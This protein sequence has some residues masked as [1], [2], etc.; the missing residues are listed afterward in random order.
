MKKEIKDLLSRRFTMTSLYIRGRADRI[1]VHKTLPIV[2]EWEVKTHAN[3]KYDDLTME[4]LPLAHHISKL[5]LGVDCLY[6]VNVN[7]KYEGCF[8]VSNLPKIRSVFSPGRKEYE[9]LEPIFDDIIHL[10]F[11][12]KEIMRW[13]GGGSK[14]PFIIIDKSEMQILPDWRE[15]ILDL[16]KCAFS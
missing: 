14:D 4:L 10:Y 2:F 6:I 1:A 15:S 7:Q 11:P 16:S 9:S 8:W 13:G 5:H 3:P 12:G